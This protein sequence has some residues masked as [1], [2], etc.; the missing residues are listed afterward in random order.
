MCYLCKN[1]YFSFNG[2]CYC[3]INNCE[4]C[5]ENTCLKCISGYFYNSTTR[6]CEKQNDEDKIPCYDINCE[7][8]YSSEKGA[9]DFCKSGFT[10]KKGECY[11]LPIPDENLTCPDNYYLSGNIC[12]EKCSR[13]KNDQ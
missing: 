3:E 4:Q 11:E 1:G 2:D 7:T 13:N 5:G 9:C 6:S 8:C 10:D 12:I